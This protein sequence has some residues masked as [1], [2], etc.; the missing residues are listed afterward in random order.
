[1]KIYYACLLVSSLIILRKSL[2]SDLKS[3]MTANNTH[4]TTKYVIYKGFLNGSM[5]PHLNGKEIVKSIQMMK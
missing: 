2:L 3:W 4:P 5:I 1:M